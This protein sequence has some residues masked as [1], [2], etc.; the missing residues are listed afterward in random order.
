NNDH[1]GRASCPRSQSG[2]WDGRRW[3]V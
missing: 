1:G 2:P 3:L